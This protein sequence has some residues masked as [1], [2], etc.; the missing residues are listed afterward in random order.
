[1]PL[2][3]ALIAISAIG[4]LALVPAVKRLAL[5]LGAVDFPEE[6]RKIHV[7]ATPRLG[8][9]AIFFSV[10]LVVCLAT[11]YFPP[12]DPLLDIWQLAA[13][14]V[15]CVSVFLVGLY[16]DIRGCKPLTKL[17]VQVG[18]ASLVYFSGIG[19]RQ[20][21]TP[22]G[23][24]LSVGLIAFPLTLL[25]I[26]G[27]SNGMNLLD[28]IDGL[29]AGVSAMGALTIL[30]VSL[31]QGYSEVTL[32]AAALLG[33][34]LGFLA[35]NFPPASVFL[36]DCGALSLG[37][38]LA[39][40]PIIGSQKAATAVTLFVPIIALGIPIFDTTLAV[41]RRTARGK[42]PFEPDRQHIHHRL[43]AVGLS[44]RQV[45]LTLY[46]VSALL[47]VL[48]IFMSNASRAGALTVLV[49][50]GAAGVVA[51]RQLGLAE[52]HE[53]WRRFRHG[54]RRRRPPH[55]RTILVRNTVP[56]L[57]RCETVGA[58]ESLLEDVRKE[59]EFDALRIRFR[60]DVLRLLSDNASPIPMGRE[61]SPRADSVGEHGLSPWSC[62][63]EICC[64]MPRSAAHRRNGAPHIEAACRVANQDCQTWCG[65]VVGE[66]VACKPL[67]KRR[68][69]GEQD[70]ELLRELA[71]GLG[72]WIATRA[73]AVAVARP[74][75]L[76][77][78][79]DVEGQAL[80]RAALER[81]YE[82]ISAAD[83]LEAIAR[84]DARPPDLILLDG[85][86]ARMDGHAACRSLK[87]DP[88]TA[89]TPI[90]MLTTSAE[91]AGSGRNGGHGN[92]ADGYIVTPC[93]GEAL[94]N[95]VAWVLRNG[96]GS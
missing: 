24:D 29:A 67:W 72:R 48:A 50:V 86:T 31:E 70:E 33:G 74:R 17:T 52:F 53:L 37:F 59:L 14:V 55:R 47:T 20:I 41:I 51:L 2:H 58:V 80:I 43:L 56:L 88:R 13:L 91:M 77:G 40:M 57:D 94:R 25:W 90:I 15:A 27:L 21:S 93:D 54:E 23:G 4:C 87:A 71:Q 34:L 62:R 46:A 89:H 22:F 11:R 12:T 18:A 82:V 44:Q 84:A 95:K 7:H 85:T 64:E 69:A 75:I 28:G 92:G 73:C 79:A 49:V 1:M 6:D 10:L 26:V 96:N 78:S 36:G 30:V 39:V 19:I 16:D 8:G 61:T 35:F 68:R 63:A 38:L 3:L 45:T 76:V 60:S 83:G 65:R 81:A 9:A 66:L 42:H 32:V 5:A